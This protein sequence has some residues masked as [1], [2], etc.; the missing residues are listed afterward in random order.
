[1]NRDEYPTEVKKALGDM[2]ANVKRWRNRAHSLRHKRDRALV[3]EAELREMLR[4]L[5]HE[6]DR[7][8]DAGLTSD[9][10]RCKWYGESA[11]LRQRAH[12]LC[13][14]VVPTG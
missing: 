14:K 7:M 1:M 9:D 8:P 6:F 2:A 3:R 5:V 12:A 11:V 4:R 10:P 13:D